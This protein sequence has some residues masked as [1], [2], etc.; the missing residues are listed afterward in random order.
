MRVLWLRAGPCLPLHHGGRVYSYHLITRL[1]AFCHVHVL[2]STQGEEKVLAGEDAPYGQIVERVK[3]TLTMPEWS[4]KKFCAY[5]W[6]I[7][8]NLFA[9][10]EPLCL[11]LF[12][13]EVLSKRGEE[14]AGSG[15]FDVV[16]ADGL[17]LAVMVEKWKL[18]NRAPIVLLQHNV[19]SVIWQR[20]AQV[21][22]NPVTWLFYHEMARRLRRREPELCRLFDGV[23]AISTVDETHLRQSYR[24]G[25]VRGVVPIG[26]D[27]PSQAVPRS[28]IDLPDEPVIAFVG[29]MNYQ[30]NADA[31]FWFIKDVLPVIK[32][33]FSKVR[34]RVIGRHPP[35][36]LMRAARHDPS[37][38][39]TGVVEEV[40]PLLRESS[41]VVVPLRAGSGVRLKIMESL[42]AGL[43]VVSTRLGAEGLPLEDGRDL[44]FADDPG[45]FAHAVLR[46]LQD[47][48]LRRDLAE[49]GMERARTDFAWQRSAVALFEVLTA[50]GGGHGA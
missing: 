47:G 13:E 41:V 48:G 1:A 15:R 44:L 22:R 25:N 14:L 37:L 8:R 24:L 32:R 49:K 26:A 40:L 31:V 23:T 10:R 29:S 33:T 19:E 27:C 5:L 4:P 28:V 9:S 11:T 35:F 21:Q 46:L 30:P 12:N 7:I 3:S 43:P 38:E 42:S 17:Y 50:V 18:K 36:A 16:V 20:V 39:V 2:E 45:S 6:P 34:F